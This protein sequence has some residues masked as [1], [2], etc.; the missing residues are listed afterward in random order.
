MNGH[1]G[2]LRSWLPAAL[3]VCA[4]LVL[5]ATAGATT[6]P[7]YTVT[8]DST[9]V[10]HFLGIDNQPSGTETSEYTATVPLTAASGGAFTGSVQASYAQATGTI[11]SQ[12]QANGTTGTNTEIEQS[13][14]PQPFGAS[15]T[16]ATGGGGTLTITVGSPPTG[17]PTEN[18][19]DSTTC[20]PGLTTGNTTPR[21]YSDFTEEHRAQLT[22][23]LSAFQFTFTLTPGSG[24]TVGSYTSSQSFTNNNLTVDETTT[25]TVT[26][27]PCNVPDV[28]GEQLSVAESDLTDNGCTVGAITQKKSTT[29]K[30]EV[31]ASSPAAGAELQPQA[32]VSLVVSKGMTVKAK[33]KVP[34]L[35]GK[36]LAAAKPLLKLAGCALGTVTL[37]TGSKIAVGHVISSDPR[38]GTTKSPGA[39]VALTVSAKPCKV[40]KVT[41]KPVADAV[42]ALQAAGCGIGP[43]TL[44]KAS[45]SSRGRV[46]SQSPGS[47]KSVAPG[48]K[49]KLTVGG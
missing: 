42:R 27:T 43:I 23:Q 16:P 46:L 18:Y 9:Q 17:W 2:P 29:A 7:P 10:N 24:D 49:V 12:C 47:G 48:T 21:W 36:P 30:G 31:M 40:P 28:V 22:S 41:G 20:P 26:Q 33:C 19:Q 34:K 45:A 35:K 8:F 3:A 37:K 5:P 44:Q 11:T 4:A 38:A 14:N 25:I 6:A 1:R 32:P 13:G 15:L 39:K